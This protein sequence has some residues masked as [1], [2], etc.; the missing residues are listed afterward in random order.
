[1]GGVGVEVL[2]VGRG[3]L[4]LDRRIGLEFADDGL[5][6]GVGICRAQRD[7]GEGIAAAGGAG[8]AVVSRNGDRVLAPVGEG[9]IVD[10]RGGVGVIRAVAVGDGVA[11]R[12]ENLH[13]RDQV[14]TRP[15]D[16]HH[17]AVRRGGVQ[18]PILGEI[19]V[20]KRA[21]DGRAVAQD[22]RLLGGFGGRFRGRVLRPCA[23][24]REQ[25]DH[26]GGE[27]NETSSHCIPFL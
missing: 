20:V 11:G 4:T 23:A 9:V 8:F 3:D 18:R 21:R 6:V 24:E 5:V 2:P 14:A 17:H 1:M 26:E 19:G 25:D 16:R 15:R 10:L 7:H 27:K 12:V 13:V 22:R